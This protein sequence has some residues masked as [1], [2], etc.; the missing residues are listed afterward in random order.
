MITMHDNGCLF[1]VFHPHNNHVNNQTFLLNADVL[2]VYYVSDS[3]QVILSSFT[4]EGIHQLEADFKESGL[5]EHAEL[6]S[7]YMFD[8]PVL[9][10]FVASN[11]D[12]FEDFAALINAGSDDD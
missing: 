3:G 10:E 11:F 6:I 4:E 1:M 2:G 9:Y 5:S 12:D 7:R 8:E